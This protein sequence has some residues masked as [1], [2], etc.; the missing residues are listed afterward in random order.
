MKLETY[1]GR[2][3]FRLSV[4]EQP[5]GEELD[6]VLWACLIGFTQ[7]L[8]NDGTD[9][10]SLQVLDVLVLRTHNV[11]SNLIHTLNNLKFEK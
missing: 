7:A 5:L 10:V 9:V 2:F 4:V 11:G 8:G 1:L 3:S 6:W